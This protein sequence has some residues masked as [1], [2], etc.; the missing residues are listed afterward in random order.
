MFG[1]KD[2]RLTP[3][4]LKIRE[5]EETLFSDLAAPPSVLHNYTNTAGSNEDED[6]DANT[7]PVGKRQRR[8]NN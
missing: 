3:E 2:K 6:S 1:A 5:E 8:T 4:E 7:S